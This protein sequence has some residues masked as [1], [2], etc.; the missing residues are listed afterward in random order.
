MSDDL[1]RQVWHLEG[2]T[3]VLELMLRAVLTMLV[4]NMRGPM[5]V[6]D[7]F[8]TEFESTLGN[9]DMIGID[10]EQSDTLRQMLKAVFNDSMNGVRARI[11][12]SAQAQASSATRN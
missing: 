8:V 5:A 6:I 9:I 7:T 3:I 4:E 12:S 10:Q 1:A 11:V 2:R